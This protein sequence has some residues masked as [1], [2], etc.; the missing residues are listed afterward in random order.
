MVMPERWREQLHQAATQVDAELVLQ[1]IRQIPSEHDTLALALTELVNH[2][3]FDRLVTIT[4]P[5]P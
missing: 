2:Y 3:R 4:Q 5:Q 1:L